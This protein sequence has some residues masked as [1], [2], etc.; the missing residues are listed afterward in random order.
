ME[1]TLRIFSNVFIIVVL[2]AMGI[3]LG[4]F[5]LGKDHIPLF[6]IESPL[7]F[8][9][10]VAIM[11]FVAIVINLF[12]EW[13]EFKKTARVAPA[14]STAEK[15]AETIKQLAVVLVF[16][17]AC[18]IYVFLLRYLHFLV[19]TFIFLAAGLFLMNESKAK[20]GKRLLLA[21]IASLVSVPLFYATFQLVFNVMLP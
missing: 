15:R 17:A 19:G 10:L 11:L 7:V 6:S 9:F 1:K 4:V 3:S 8:A 14:S 2:L 16:A 5:T 13:K 21:G 12:Q 20:V 18:I